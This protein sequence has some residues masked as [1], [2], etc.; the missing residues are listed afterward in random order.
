M[1]CMKYSVRKFYR[2]FCVLSLSVF[3]QACGGG[4]SSSSGG[5]GGDD[6]SSQATSIVTLGDSIG[7]GIGFGASTSWPNELSGILGVPLLE[8][9]SRASEMTDWGVSQ[10][11]G[12][13]DRNNASHVVI[14]LGTNDALR[15][16][17]GAA[18]SNLQRVADIA[19]S[20]GVIPVI[21][22]VILNTRSSSANA[23]AQQISV[24]ILGIQGARIV[25]TRGVISSGLL[26][27]GIHPTNAGQRAIAQAFASVF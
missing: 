3:I 18:I 17:V 20:R 22:T 25:N 14:L 21:G 8:N 1:I 12:L 11:N 27:D 16:S 2:L 24:G 5:G 15:G 26:A 23:R 4:S 13:L 19:N 9:R 10:I 7:V 6:S